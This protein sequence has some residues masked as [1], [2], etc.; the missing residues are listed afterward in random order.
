MDV[1]VCEDERV[2]RLRRTGSAVGLAFAAYDVW[3]RLSPRQRRALLAYARRYGPLIAAKA[4][5]SAK[6]AAASRARKPES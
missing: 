6:G 5:Q 3:L 4:A 1:S 2:P